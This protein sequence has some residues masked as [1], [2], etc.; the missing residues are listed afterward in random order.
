MASIFG[1]RQK[2]SPNKKGQQN[3]VNSQNGRDSFSPTTNETDLIE[4][5]LNGD[6]SSANGNYHNKNNRHSSST[7]TPQIP[8]PPSNTNYS[9]SQPNSDTRYY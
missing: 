2:I 9:P 5:S 8:P 7:F 1:R 4:N 3:G 6:S